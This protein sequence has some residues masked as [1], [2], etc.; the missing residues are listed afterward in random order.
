MTGPSPPSSTQPPPL[1]PPSGVAGL[2]ALALAEAALKST[3]EPR[4]VPV[5][6]Q[7]TVVDSLCVRLPIGF[8]A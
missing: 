4:A 2:A 1:A 8:M 3:A 7:T 5:A 6:G